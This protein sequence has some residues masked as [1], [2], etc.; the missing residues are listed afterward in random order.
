MLLVSGWLRWQCDLW[1]MSADGVA[2]WK[3]AGSV[4]LHW[5]SLDAACCSVKPD[6]GRELIWLIPH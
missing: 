2:A 4:A 5:S 1:L 6:E 3:T